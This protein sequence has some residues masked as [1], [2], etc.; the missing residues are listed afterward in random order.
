MNKTLL[1]IE[2]NNSSTYITGLCLYLKIF[3]LEDLEVMYKFR[4]ASTTQQRPEP[5]KIIFPLFK[6][7]VNEPF[8]SQSILY[9]FSWKSSGFGKKTVKKLKSKLSKY[10]NFI[11]W[12]FAKSDSFFPLL[13]CFFPFFA[14]AGTSLLW[15]NFYKERYTQ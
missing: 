15:P 12:E 9:A 6:F 3:F 14:V 7:C 11:N 10:M 13:S 2:K 8:H 5:F 4:L 1:F